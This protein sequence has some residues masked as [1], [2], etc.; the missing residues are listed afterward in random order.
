MYIFKKKTDSKSK[1]NSN[2]N[3]RNG[4]LTQNELRELVF[5]SLRRYNFK[6][7]NLLLSTITITKIQFEKHSSKPIYFHFK[8]R[9]K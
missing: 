7:T 1:S 5:I 9:F 3:F 4:I 8:D 6:L 2:D